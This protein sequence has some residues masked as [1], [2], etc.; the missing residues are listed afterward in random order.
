MRASSR[1][2][3]VPLLLLAPVVLGCEGPTGFFSGGAL[4]GP[5]A[6]AP[7]GWVLPSGASWGTGQL[8]TNPADP[9]SV[10][11]NYTIVEGVLYVNAGDTETQWVVNMDADP[12][13]RL[14]IDGT[15]YELRAE[16]VTDRAEVDRF[17]PAWTAQGA[18]ARD[19]SELDELWLYRLRPR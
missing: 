18:W 2:C 8:E 16:R 1:V 6:T 14:R 13:V 15:V 5:V 3:L 12:R 17:A 7:D 9:Y 11:L 10:N 4:S 19:P